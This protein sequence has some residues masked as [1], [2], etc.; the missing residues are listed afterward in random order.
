MYK[1][2]KSSKSFTLLEL[3]IVMTVLAI[4]A[5]ILLVVVKPQQIF[6]KAR[7][8]QRISDIARIDKAIAVATAESPNISTGDAKT[9]YLSLQDSNS[10]CSTY[11]TQLPT[12][13]SGWVYKC[14]NTPKNTDS[15]GWIPINFQSIPILNLDS[16]PLDSKNQPPYFYSYIKG[17]SYKL[18]AHM[19]VQFNESSKDG[20][21]DPLYYEAGDD[22]SI[23][24]YHTGLVMYMP[25]DSDAKDYSGNGNNGINNGAT[26][27]TGKV[28]GALN[29]DGVDDNV[30]VLD[31]NTLS[32]VEKVTVAAWIYPVSAAGTD[33]KRIVN[34]SENS[35][36]GEYTLWLYND[37]RMIWYVNNWTLGYV[38]ST[39][40]LLNKWI[41][42]V[43]VFD[44][45]I[46]SNKLKIYI[47]GEL[48]NEGNT[49]SAS[50]TNTAYNLY[51]GNWG[52]GTR[53]FNGLIDEVRIYNRALSSDEIKLMYNA[54]K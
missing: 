45:S 31:A 24:N 39:A 37:G 23:P 35:D 16:I 29:F 21:I 12:L 28:S 40:V 9:V 49:T 2:H 33:Y 46:G 42:V 38:F 54:T 19:E 4:L 15:T 41:Y 17:G 51:V 7:D 36:D 8:T 18:T 22:K 13:P 26:Q 43:G 14:S 11:Q 30:R 10:N 34:K 32:P 53:P 44:G 1:N 5:S 3:L 47:N 20:G 52:S 6:A 27:T 50:I 25:F 48:N